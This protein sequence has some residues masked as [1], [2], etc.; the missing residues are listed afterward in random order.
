MPKPV[1]KDMSPADIDAVAD[2]YQEILSKSNLAYS[3]DRTILDLKKRAA[4]MNGQTVEEWEAGW[5]MRATPTPPAAAP[6]STK[7]PRRKSVAG[8][9]VEPIPPV[10]EE[11]KQA[12]GINRVR[13]A[14]TGV[15]GS[16]FWLSPENIAIGRTWMSLRQDAGIVM[17]MLAIGPSGCGKTEGLRRLAEQFDKPFYKVDCAA[18]TTADKWVGHKDI[19]VTSDGPSTTYTLSEF[20]RWLSADGF[21]PG[22]VLLDEVNRLHPSL[23]NMLIPV[24]DGSQA[25]WVPELGIY[26]KVHPD[27]MIAATANIGVGFSGTYALDVA[28]HDRFGVVLEQGFP[29]RDEEIK[30]LVKRTGIDEPR[31]KI[32]VDIA[33]QAR[34]KADAGEINRPVST[35]ALLDAAVWATTGMTITQACEATFAK[36]Y[37]EEGK[38]SSERTMVRLILQGVA[39]NR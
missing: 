19:V 24:L 16:Y 25:V 14:V 3:R 30:I 18:I 26:V 33:A 37:S 1:H 13:G 27:T 5:R 21:D 39:G 22:V 35:R 23:L 20:L 2:E 4:E 9:P 36:K 11:E 31:A 34:Q 7:K 28:L 38:G 6:T 17:N 29:P 15:D 32:L 12:A 8:D 10:T